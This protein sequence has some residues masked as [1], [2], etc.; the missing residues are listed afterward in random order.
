MNEELIDKYADKIEAG[1]TALAQ[2]LQ[3]PAEHVY[4]LFVRQQVIEGVTIL[5]L[6]LLGITLI[7]GCIITGF[8]NMK[9]ISGVCSECQPAY[10]VIPF[11][12]SALLGLVIVISISHK[13]SSGI[14]QILNPEYYAIQEIGRLLK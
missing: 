3:A 12:I 1:L 4:E 8:R 11:A 9:R 5:L 13:A 2:Q 6:L 7:V 14:T 10:S